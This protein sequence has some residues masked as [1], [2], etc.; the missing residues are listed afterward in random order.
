MR[1][2]QIARVAHEAN[3]AL[4]VELGDPAVSPHWGDA[5]DWQKDSAVEGVQ[6]ALEGATPEGLH[7]SWCDFKEE[8]GWV[9]G[10][11]KDADAKTHPCLVPYDQLP[12][13]QRVKDELFFQIV[14]ALEHMID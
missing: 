8:D 4:Q 13:E 14:R 6:Q 2:E 7:E 1:A 3:R 9:Y 11:V 5:P 10:E 12:A